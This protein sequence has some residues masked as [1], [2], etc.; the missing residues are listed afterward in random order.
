MRNSP[1]T[2]LRPP[3]APAEL[4]GRVLAACREAAAE[5]AQGLLDRIWQSRQMR[6]AWL[7]VV[8]VL[9]LANL[10]VLP[11]PDGGGEPRVSTVAARAELAEELGLARWWWPAAGSTRWADIGPAGSWSALEID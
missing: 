9:W 10:A 8:I 11:S 1:F 6:R 4:R 7:V 5:K 3:R 2:S